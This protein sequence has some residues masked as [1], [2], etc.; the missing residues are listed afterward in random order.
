MEKE[1]YTLDKLS[2]GEIK[3]YNRKKKE[4]E[5]R[6]LSSLALA[7]ASPESLGFAASRLA[8]QRNIEETE[9]YIKETHHESPYR[10][11]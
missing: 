4:K 9:E 3:E 11:K 6:I 8:E 2:T 5:E 7:G 10:S 1:I